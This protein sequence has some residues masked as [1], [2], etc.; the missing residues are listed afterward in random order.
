MINEKSN[1]KLPSYFQWK[2]K[3]EIK[4]LGNFINIK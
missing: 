1:T 3:N 2:L 4:Q